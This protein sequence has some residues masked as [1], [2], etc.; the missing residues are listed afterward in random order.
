MEDCIFCK[1]VNGEIPSSK[2]FENHKV[3]AF[4]DINPASKGH[5]LVIPKKHSS[6]LLE[7]EDSDLKETA[8]SLK[9]VAK[10]VVEATGAKAFNILQNNGRE[11]GQLIEHFHWHIIPRSVD[12]GTQLKLAKYKCEEG[13]IES[14]RE[15]IKEKLEKVD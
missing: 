14:L 15:K 11:A 13:E 10:A 9:K 7:I 6:S 8:V 1:I 12:D 3:I 4:L 2:V 5:C